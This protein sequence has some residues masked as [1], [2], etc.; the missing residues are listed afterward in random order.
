MA[1]FDNNAT[2]RPSAEVQAAFEEALRESWVNPSSPYRS[3]VEVRVRLNQARECIARSLEVDAGSV[4]FTSGSTEANNAVFAHAARF[5]EP[6]AWALVSSI[7][8]PSVLAP[9]DHWFAERNQIVPVEPTGVVDLDRLSALLDE[10]SEVRF[11]SLMAAN[12]ETGVLQPWREVADL[13]REREIHFH[14]DA[15]QWIGKLPSSG[16]SACSS[17]SASAHKLGGPKGVGIL[18]SDLPRPFIM[19]GSQ[20][21]GRRSGTE[22]YPAVKAMSVACER[23]SSRLPEFAD[24]SCWR[25]SFEARMLVDF[26]GLQIL[27][28]EVPRLWNT[29]MLL[30][31]DYENLRYVGKLDKFGFEV[32]TGSACSIGKDDASAVSLAMGFSPEQTKRLVRISSYAEQTQSDWMSLGRA[33]CD[34]R[35]ELNQDSSGSSVISP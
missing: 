35:D 2:T 20:E 22:N 4:T 8:H 16:F 19:G 13:C 15:T 28:K 3:G 21:D 23:M 14:C 17:F 34:A 31:P 33:F 29:S 27:G 10:V 6:S 18:V 1:Y 9:A 7:E 32:S 12:N 24:R 30:M 5:F 11:V 26:P 25:D